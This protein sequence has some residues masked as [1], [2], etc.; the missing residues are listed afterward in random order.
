M[1]K[2]SIV[3]PSVDNAR[4]LET[5]L[6][7][8]L[9]NRPSDCEIVVP[10]CG[11]YDDPYNIADEVRLVEVPAARTEMELLAVAWSMCRAPIVHTLAAGATV[12]AGWIDSVL[13]KFERMDVG[14]VTP[15]AMFAE[16]DEPVFGVQADAMGVRAAGTASSM[17][18]P[19]WQ[20]AFYRYAILEALGGFCT[21][22]E[23][24]ADLDVALWIAQAGG[25][26]Q[27]ASDCQIEMNDPCDLNQVTS[28]RIRLA[29]TLQLRHQNWFAAQG[30]QS[31]K[32]GWLSRSVG[33]GSL[34][35]MM[36]AL[37][38]KADTSAAQHRLPNLDEVRAVIAGQGQTFR[39][40]PR[41]EDSYAQHHRHAA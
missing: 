3:I 36:S 24:Y 11:Y 14:A 41:Q 12:E 22:L 23:E 15:A 16:H 7:S 37:T 21:R 6:V 9:E 40:E 34:A 20:A 13:P 31:G 8:L 17:Q 39:F 25:V 19:M 2:V 35:T 26:C 10:H 4:R 33:S 38:A 29:K 32:L 30:K 1:L 5:T 27:V 28:T 18:G